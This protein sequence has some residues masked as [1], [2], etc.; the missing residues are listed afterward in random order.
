MLALLD[1]KIRY[2]NLNQ[3][4]FSIEN[5]VNVGIFYGLVINYIFKI[6]IDFSCCLHDIENIFFQSTGI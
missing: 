4:Y 5:I 2:I 1:G 3:R 6:L